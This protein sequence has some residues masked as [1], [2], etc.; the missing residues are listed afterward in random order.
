MQKPQVLCQESVSYPGDREHFTVFLPSFHLIHIFLLPL[1]QCSISLIVGED[2]YRDAFRVKQLHL[3]S[4]FNKLGISA[5][6]TACFQMKLLWPRWRTAQISWG[7]G[8][9]TQHWWGSQANLC[10]FKASLAY[11]VSSRT[12]RATQGNTTSRKQEQ[13]KRTAEIF[14][15]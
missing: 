6:T 2:W 4:A 12:A 11:R 3:F 5:L 8:V 13:T 14:W 15:A 1:L 10:E 7:D 9:H